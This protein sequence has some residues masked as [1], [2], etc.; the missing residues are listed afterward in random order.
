ME[1]P[2][3]K[4]RRPNFSEA[5][6][7]ALVTEVA[8]RKEMIL[9]KLDSTRCTLQLKN[10]AWGEVLNAVNAV[11]R[12]TRNVTEIRRKFSDLRVSVKKK[13]AQD[14]KYAGGT[15]EER[16][17]T[18]GPSGARF[19]ASC[20]R[21]EFMFRLVQEKDDSIT[22]I[23]NEDIQEHDITVPI[24]HL[25]PETSAPTNI[26]GFS[27]SGT[28]E[29]ETCSSSNTRQPIA[30][31]TEQRSRSSTPSATAVRSTVTGDYTDELGSSP[32]PSTIRSGRR[33][34]TSSARKDE[35]LLREMLRVQTQMRDSFFTACS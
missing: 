24:V 5:E 2:P 9:G 15:E 31:T 22:L 21:E 29:V 19:T 3:A 16:E 23:L 6:V 35:D 12:V 25:E 26:P 10:H 4:K 1:G 17:P 14:K 20:F 32:M 8:K 11:G 28:Y 33:P 30:A 34:R 13:A 18:P 7:Y 27:S